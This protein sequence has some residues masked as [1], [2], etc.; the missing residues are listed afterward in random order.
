M[1]YCC[2]FVF[3]SDCISEV[4]PW[5]LFSRHENIIMAGD[6]ASVRS[7]IQ[8]IKI[9]IKVSFPLLAYFFLGKMVVSCNIF[10]AYHCIQPHCNSTLI[11]FRVEHHEDSQ[12]QLN[13]LIKHV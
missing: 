13:K 8:L 12:V 11:V 10:P 2:N 1:L 5:D 3:K 4:L 9:R 7:F 6:N